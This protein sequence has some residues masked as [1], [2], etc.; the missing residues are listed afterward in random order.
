V[1]LPD[2]RLHPTIASVTIR[3]G[4]RTAQ[5]TLTDEPN[6]RWSDW[7]SGGMFVYLSGGIHPWL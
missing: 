1:L 3:V 7:I 2:K 4:A 5:A 6:V